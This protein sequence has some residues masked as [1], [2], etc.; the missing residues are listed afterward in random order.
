MS[1]PLGSVDHSSLNSWVVGYLDNRYHI[2]G[3][4][5]ELGQIDI[6]MLQSVPLGSGHNQVGALA[7]GMNA[8]QVGGGVQGRIGGSRD[9]HFGD[10]GREASALVTGRFEG[11]VG[12]TSAIHRDKGFV[13]ISVTLHRVP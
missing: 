6:E 5:L 13:L 12:V 2:R 8:A 9:R 10:G 4:R 11:G 7:N 1:R 3:R